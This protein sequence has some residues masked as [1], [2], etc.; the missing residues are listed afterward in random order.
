MTE[1]TKAVRTEIKVVIL[2]VMVGLVLLPA[3]TLLFHDIIPPWVPEPLTKLVVLINHLVQVTVKSD[4]K[5]IENIQKAAKTGDM[6]Q[7]MKVLKISPS[8]L[9][10]KSGTASSGFVENTG[11][12]NSEGKDPKAAPNIG[13]INFQGIAYDAGG[14]SQLIANN[15]VYSAGD[16]VSGYRVK[17]V[18]EFE[19]ILEK[20]GSTY[21]IS[22]SGLSKRENG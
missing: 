18:R 20:D 12:K 2:A 21:S 5:M 15:D 11:G 16:S 9:H 7:V 3:K 4:P 13:G 8:D 10:A 1:G 19:A 14:A 22:N 17:E 6:Q